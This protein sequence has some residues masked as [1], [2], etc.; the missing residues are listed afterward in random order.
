MIHAAAAREPRRSP[1]LRQLRWSAQQ[2]RSLARRLLSSSSMR[3]LAIGFIWLGCAVAWLVLG[4]TLQ[5][6]SGESSGELHREVSELWGAP[7][8]QLPLQAHYRERIERREVTSTVDP[9]G[10]ETQTV[11]RREEWKDVPL[12]LVGTA[13]RVQLALE[14]RRKGLLWFPT[15]VADVEL[16]YGVANDTDAVREVHHRFPFP[17]SDVSLDGFTVLDGDGKQ[18]PVRI[19][20]GGAN[21]TIEVPPGARTQHT[22]RYRARG[23]SRWEYGLGQGGEARDVRLAVETD[24]ADVDFP[25][26]T[27]SPTR[28]GPRGTGWEGVWEFERLITTRALGIELPQLIN[29]GPLASRITFF[30]PV[31]LLFFFFVVALLAGVRGRELHPLHYFLLGCAFFAYHLLFA[32]LVDLLALPLAFAVSSAVSVFLVVTYARLFTG[33]LF[34]LREIALAQL[35]YLVVFSLTF[36]L[37]GLTGLAITVLAILTLFMMMQVTGRRSPVSPAKPPI[38]PSPSIAT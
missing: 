11:Q 30:A 16:S 38:Q 5:V 6:R 18:R 26:G 27:L 3:L 34:A 17:G 32:Y 22:V 14:Q 1:A 37:E 35:I 4:T 19:E 36:L 9:Q 15:Y 25:S 8:V 13:G 29:P 10:R 21:W 24:F 23:T 33:W 20:A 7:M 2:V 31:G 28:H 12:P